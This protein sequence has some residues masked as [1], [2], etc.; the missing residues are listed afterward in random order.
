MEGIHKTI[1]SCF[2]PLSISPSLWRFGE[3]KLVSDEQ[4]GSS[5]DGIAK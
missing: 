2:C 3:L 4:D 5:F 1:I